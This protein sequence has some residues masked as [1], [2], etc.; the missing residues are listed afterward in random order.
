MSIDVRVNREKKI[1]VDDLLERTLDLG[2]SFALWRHPSAKEKILMICNSGAVFQEE[3]VLENSKSGFALSPFDPSGKKIFF[4]AD[5]VF[6][7]KGDEMINGPD[8]SN[9]KYI[10]STAEKTNGKE[11][12]KYYQSKNN[13]T[14]TRDFKDLV[15]VCID[16]INEGSFEKIVTSRFQDVDLPENFD[17]LK[18]FD[19]MCNQHPDAFVS[20]VSSP[21]TGTWLGASPEL[22]VST[23]AQDKFRTI[24]LAGTQRLQPSTNLKS[25]AWTQKEIEEQ[26]LV[27]RYIINCFKKI[28][29]REYTEQGP[30]TIVAGSLLHLRTDYEVDMKE[31]NFPQLG[32]VMLKLLH[33]TSAV[34]GMPLE[35]SLH[36]LKKSE[37]YNREFYS[38]YLGPI[39]F[40]GESKIFVNLRCMQLF[41]GKARIYAGAGVTADSVAEKENEE[42]ELKI[43]TLTKIIFS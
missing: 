29:V 23:D 43:N 13:F 2:G 30:R 16:K 27:S 20:L 26:A 15:N 9:T 6:T 32:S 24:A 33:P 42:A 39:N 7:F 28:R 31:V 17:L 3:T 5:L 18:A 21:E 40:E 36:F 19:R 41:D 11:K 22:L 38:G 25:V 14:P 12:L 34:C 37:G 10:S 35:P 4:N 8:L 1:Q